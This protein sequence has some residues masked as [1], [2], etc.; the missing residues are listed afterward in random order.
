MDLGKDKYRKKD[1]LQKPKF[2]SSKPI[3]QQEDAKP[4]ELQRPTFINKNLENK[5]SNFVELNT[6]GD[7]IY[8]DHLALP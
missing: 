3:I 8:N 1:D 5:P 4:I 2:T 6:Q 7:V